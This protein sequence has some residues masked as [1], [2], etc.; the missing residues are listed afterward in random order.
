MLGAR[1]PARPPP[2]RRT[3]IR[4]QRRP[5]PSPTRPPTTTRCGACTPCGREL[6]RAADLVHM[7]VVGLAGKALSCCYAQQ[8]GAPWIVP[9]R[10]STFLQLPRR[11]LLRCAAPP[12]CSSSST[13]SSSRCG[14]GRGGR[15]LVEGIAPSPRS[16]GSRCLQGDQGPP[17]R[18]HTNGLASAAA[19][20]ASSKLLAT[21]SGG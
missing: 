9:A 19:Q 17:C 15:C 20:A 21:V 7:F 16:G 2:R 1:L 5:R 13:R 8:R 12:F 14:G 6:G 11:P 3:S 4:L 18:L 10:A